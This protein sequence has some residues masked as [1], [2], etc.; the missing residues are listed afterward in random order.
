VPSTDEQL[1]YLRHLAPFMPPLARTGRA[2]S[3]ARAAELAIA[4]A[5]TGGVAAAGAQPLPARRALMADCRRYWAAGLEPRYAWMGVNAEGDLVLDLLNGCYAWLRRVRP[6]VGGGGGG[7]EDEGGGEAEGDDVAEGVVDVAPDGGTTSGAAGKRGRPKKSAATTRSRSTAPPPQPSSSLAAAAAPLPLDPES[8]PPLD[9]DAHYTAS[10]Q[11]PDGSHQPLTISTLSDAQMFWPLSSDKHAQLFKSGSRM[12][13][14]AA[15]QAAATELHRQLA[16]AE[17]TLT[18][19]Q[20]AELA[21]LAQRTVARCIS[22]VGGWKVANAQETF[23]QHLTPAGARQ[24][25]ALRAAGLPTSRRYTALDAHREL[26]RAAKA[27]GLPE[28]PATA[29]QLARIRELGVRVPLATPLAGGRGGSPEV[30]GAPTTTISYMDSISSISSSPTS[31]G[32]SS[33]SQR[34]HAVLPTAQAEDPPKELPPLTY[35]QARA[36]LFKAALDGEAE[37]RRLQEASKVV[38]P[39]STVARLRHAASKYGVRHGVF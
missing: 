11:L 24:L 3:Y 1:F 4:Q 37:E 23:A 19:L 29:A 30:G 2:L 21:F 16:R 9:R 13:S 28:P 5:L 18:R 7:N 25:E 17:M 22:A 27:R 20:S 12:G 38:P 31:K 35:S 6:G 32:S 33:S 15:R 8:W 39:R 14:R 26:L 36:L 10:L 34:S